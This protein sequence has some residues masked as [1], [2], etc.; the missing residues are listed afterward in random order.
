MQYRDKILALIFDES[1]TALF[2]WIEEQPVLEQVDILKEFREIMQE[3]LAEAEDDS[4]KENLRLLEK[5]IDI[6][7]EAYL[8]EQLAALKLEMASEEQDKIF[9]EIEERIQ[10]V[11]DY[12]RECIETDA[13]NA[14]AMKEMA[15]AMIAS[16]KKNGVYDKNNWLWFH[17]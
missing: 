1:E 12:I 9:E 11:R 4:Q 8:D 10:G 7:Q 15:I 17:E 13:P 14:A 16:E 3:M 2:D 6:Y 5:Q